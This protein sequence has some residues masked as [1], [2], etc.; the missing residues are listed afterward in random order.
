[1]M[2][3]GFKP[4]LTAEGWQL[5]NAPVILM[6]AHKAALDIFEEAGMQNL[7]KKSKQLT[8]YLLFIL[9]EINNSGKEVFE[10]LTP[11][12][13]DEHGCQVSVLFLENGRE[14]FDRLKPHGIIADWR[15]PDVIR[16]SPVPLYNT[17]EDV[18]RFGQVLKNLLQKINV[19]A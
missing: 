16:F 18:F 13:E 6:A 19:Q 12:N 9:Y 14:I 3:K 5:S 17:F 10:I 15:E 8:G 7:I 2:E 11:K 4:I 1:K